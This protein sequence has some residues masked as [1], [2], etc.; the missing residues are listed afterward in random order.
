[1]LIFIYSKLA[2]LKAI[3]TMKKIIVKESQLINITE[4]VIKEQIS[5]DPNSFSTEIQDVDFYG[6]ENHFPEYKGSYKRNNRSL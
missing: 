4:K 5:D 6:L 3:Y 1:M 2:A